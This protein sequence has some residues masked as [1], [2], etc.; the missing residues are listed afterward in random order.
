MVE[1]VDVD[2]VADNAV[3]NAADKAVVAAAHLAKGSPCRWRRILPK[4]VV[5]YT[6]KL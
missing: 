2:N 4:R 3:D 6:C 5:L 1:A